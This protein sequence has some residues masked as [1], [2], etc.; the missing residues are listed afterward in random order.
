MESRPQQGTV[1]TLLLPRST[2]AQAVAE[3]ANGIARIAA[4][5]SSHDP[6]QARWSVLLVEDD[7]EVAALTAEMLAQL[8]YDATR[9]SNAAAALGA[10]ANG[11]R[12]DVVFTDVMMPG[13]MN[14]AELACE[15]RRRRPEVPVILTTGY[16]GDAVA[17]AKAQNLPLALRKPY[18][19]EALSGIL[20]AAT[21]H[22]NSRVH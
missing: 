18:R 13:G 6:S 19:L 20:N 21:S 7:D 22:V 15:I 3:H 17:A 2:K 10:L 12:I 4:Q 11:R 16:D 8:G 14:G 9:V 1:V 5:A